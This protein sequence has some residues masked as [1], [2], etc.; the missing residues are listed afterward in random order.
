MTPREFFAK[1]EATSVAL[2]SDGGRTWRAARHPPAA[3][4]SGVAYA[5]DPL[6]LVAVGLAGTFVSRDGGDSWTQTDTIPMNAV[7][8]FGKRGYAVG[9]RG[10]VAYADSIP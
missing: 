8:F 2:S 1:L 7:R 5:G 10:R 3:Y 4:L 6:K 9:P